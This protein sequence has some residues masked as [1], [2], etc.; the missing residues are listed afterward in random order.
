MRIKLF[1]NY[2]KNNLNN[3]TTKPLNRNKMEEETWCAFDDVELTAEL[4]EIGSDL[5]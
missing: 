1:K 2:Q 3:T 5:Y 4:A